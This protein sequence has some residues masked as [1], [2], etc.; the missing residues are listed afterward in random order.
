M[1]RYFFQLTD[2]REELNPHRGTELPGPAA[3]REEAIV[4]ARDL[5]E[6]KMFPGRKWDGWFVKI[7]D[8]HGHE[9]DTV[10]IDLLAQ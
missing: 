2:G 5:Q 8:E 7:T 3:A 6:G 10:P 1:P 4:I 9:V